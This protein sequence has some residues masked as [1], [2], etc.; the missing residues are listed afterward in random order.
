[1]DEGEGE[2]A[3]SLDI[4]TVNTDNLSQPNSPAELYHALSNAVSEP[5]GS[6]FQGYAS[7]FLSDSSLKSLIA[8]FSYQKTF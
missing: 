8:V 5:A 6:T 3:L 1:V 7:L 4:Q 2:G